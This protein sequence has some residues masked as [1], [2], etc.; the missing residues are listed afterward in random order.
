MS[1]FHDS[2][3]W[4]D[5]CFPVISMCV[6][7]TKPCKM[8]D[9][10]KK[11]TKTYRQILAC[12]HRQGRRRGR[13]WRGR[14]PRGGRGGRTL[15]PQPGC[16][17]VWKLDIK[18]EENCDSGHPHA[19]VMSRTI[20]KLPTVCW[21]V[22]WGPGSLRPNKNCFLGCRMIHVKYLIAKG[23]SLVFGLPGRGN[24][25]AHKD[26]SLAEAAVLSL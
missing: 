8:Q 5:G 14:G 15:W 9:H 23:K 26:L 11:R 3:H 16:N 1:K 22:F 13:G 6:N 21:L 4:P 19:K 24:V 17:T 7:S 25:S 18:P 12:L 2:A 20:A 10:F